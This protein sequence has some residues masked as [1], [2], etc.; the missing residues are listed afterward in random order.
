M[1]TLLAGRG[2]SARHRPRARRPGRPG[3]AAVHRWS[4]DWFDA[5]RDAAAGRTD[6]PV[7]A[8]QVSRRAVGLAGLA[9]LAVSVLLSFAIGAAPA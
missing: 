5:R 4:N 3:R 2:R 7:P 1:I 9:A 6:K 8:G